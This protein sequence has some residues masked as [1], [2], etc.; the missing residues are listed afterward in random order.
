MGKKSPTAYQTI[1]NISQLHYQT[2]WKL[3]ERQKSKSG[4]SPLGG[5]EKKEG[6]KKSYSS[7]AGLA[8]VSLLPRAAIVVFGEPPAGQ[9]TCPAGAVF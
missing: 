9:G 3:V 1:T 2:H 4:H 5:K 6:K 7:A 8:G